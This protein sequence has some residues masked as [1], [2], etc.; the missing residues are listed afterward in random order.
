M[1]DAVG[2]EERAY[3]ALEAQRRTL[4]VEAARAR[5]DAPHLL[6]EALLRLREA[7]E[8]LATLE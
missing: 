5:N 2:A 7:K 4:D 1:E 3:W 8:R 6:A